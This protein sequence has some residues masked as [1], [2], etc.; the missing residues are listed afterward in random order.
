MASAVTLEVHDAISI[1]TLDDGKVNALSPAVLDELHGAF[2]DASASSA[3]VLTG[4]PGIFSAGFDLKVLR[5]G[6][7]TAVEQL[8]SGFTLAEKI[9]NYPVPVIAAVSGHAM[10]MGAFLVLAADYRVGPNGHYR[11][12]I[13]EVTIGMTVPQGTLEMCRRRLT[14]AVLHR[15]LT[16]AQ[17]FEGRAA[18]DGGFFDEVVAVE[19]VRERAIEVADSFANVDR[20]SYRSTKDRLD[21]AAREAIRVGIENDLAALA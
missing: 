1:V 7:P 16:L 10:A 13:N 19:G 14:P 11:V 4:R 2:D 12:A 20:A 6:G 5:E 8:R 15:A 3:V 21:H 9:V 18:L 17:P